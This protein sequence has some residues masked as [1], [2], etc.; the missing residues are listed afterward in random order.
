M[1]GTFFSY[2]IVFF[3]VARLVSL[4]GKIKWMP[5]LNNSVKHDAVLAA[6]F[7][8]AVVLTLNLQG[9]YNQQ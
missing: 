7:S 6:I 4:T 1:I 3:I 9:I 2:F 5:T 8:M